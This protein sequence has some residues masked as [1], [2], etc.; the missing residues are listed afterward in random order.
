MDFYAY[1]LHKQLD[2][3]IANGIHYFLMAR[4]VSKVQRAGLT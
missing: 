3:E 2:I 1:A 4:R